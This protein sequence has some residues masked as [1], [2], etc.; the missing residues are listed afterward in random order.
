MRNIIKSYYKRYYAKYSRYDAK[1]SRYYAYYSRYYAKCSRFF[2]EMFALL[3]EK[4][5]FF[6]ELNRLSYISALG[7]L[8]FMLQNT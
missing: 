8:Y 4:S 7:L 2:R 1:Y 5:F 3:R 6:Y